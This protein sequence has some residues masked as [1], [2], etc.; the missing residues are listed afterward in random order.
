MSFRKTVFLLAAVAIISCVSASA[1]MSIYGMFTA[2]QLSNIKSSPVPT[3]STALSYTR[4]D[5]VNPLGG[6]GGAF[7]DFRNLGS[8]RLGVDARGTV[9]T[10]KRGAYVNFDGSGAR[11][12]SVMGGPRFSFHTPIKQLK[13]YA[14]GLF[15]LGRS[16]YGLLPT[17]S[18]GQVTIYNNF[19]WQGV[20]GLD[21]KLFPRID[22]RL[23]EFGYGGLVA[24][25]NYSH[26]YPVKQVGTGIVIHLPF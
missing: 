2:D 22:F 7:Y 6:G 4:S 20:A 15:G 24:T 14:E 1:Q 17:N 5:S 8:V 3:A 23:V 18:T 11:I 25:G 10:T 21:I 19:E 13:P 12:Y 26:N 16:D 9:V